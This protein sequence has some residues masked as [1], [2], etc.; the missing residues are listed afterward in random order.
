M[1]YPRP[2]RVIHDQGSEFTGSA[3]QDLLECTG[4]KSSPAT[5]HNPQGNS[6]IKAVHKSVG[7][8]LQTLVHLRN[9]QS[10][11]QADQ[12]S[13]DALAMA[14]HVTRCA[15]HQALHNMTPSA[16]AFC[17]DM[18]FDIPFLMDFIVLQHSRQAVID[19]HVQIANAQ[20]LRHEFQIHD[21]VLKKS[22]LSHLDKLVPSFTGPFKVIQVHTS[23]TCTIHLS[24]NQTECINIC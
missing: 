7:Q 12:L 11:A 2:V 14:M 8:V 6:V 21:Q 24:P 5:S 20:C 23:R 1:R 13:K 9:P 17:C 19:Q 18:M 3:C 16:L 10:V 4:I 22:I 15:S